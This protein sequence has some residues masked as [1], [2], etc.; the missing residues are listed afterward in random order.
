MLLNE[1]ERRQLDS[2]F[3][4]NIAIAEAVTYAQICLLIKDTSPK[5]IKTKLIQII[6]SIIKGQKDVVLASH[7]RD[8]LESIIKQ[9]INGLICQKEEFVNQLCLSVLGLYKN[10]IEA[11]FDFFE[12]LGKLAE[13]SLTKFGL[14]KPKKFIGF[15]VSQKNFETILK[16]ADTIKEHYLAYKRYRFLSI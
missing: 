8:D 4:N 1:D 5:V 14:P 6:K 9:M 11:K 10:K 13:D 7:I 12:H 15:E 3:T 2:L 16:C